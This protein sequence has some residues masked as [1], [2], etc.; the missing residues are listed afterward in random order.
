MKRMLINA[1]QQEELRV[2]LVDGQRLYDLDIESPGHE[3]KKA[4]I[5]KGK[6]TRIEPSLEAAFV[7]YGAE[8]HGFL[9]L[10]EIA[11]EY[12]PANYNSH[13]RPNIKDVLRE[14]QEVIVQID[15]EERGN[16]GAALTTFISL[17]GSYLVL[18]PNNPRAGGISRRIEGDDRTELKEALASLEL[19]DGMGLIVRT[20]GV[21]KSA[22]AL[23]WDLSFRLKHWEAIKKAAESRPAPFLIHQ[24]SN[25]IVRAFRD[26]LRQD[27][28]EILIDNP[29]VLELARQHIAA[30]GRPDFTS[31]I[32]LYTGEIPLFSH[33]QIESQIE[34]AFQREVRLPSGG[35]IVIDTTEALT[36]IDINSARATRGGDIEE[37]AFNTNLEAADEIARQLRL[38]DLGGLIV[39]DFIDMTPVRHQRAVENRL[40]EAVRQDRA[41]IQISHISRFGLL[42]MSRQRLSPSLGESSHHVCPR[43]SGTGTVRDNES[44][45]LSILRLIEEEA[46]KEN[47]KEVHAI[48]PVPIASYLLNEKRAAVSAIEA[49]Q[50]G[51]RCIIVPNDEMQTPHYHVLRVRKGEETSTLSYLLPKLHEEEMALPSDEEPAERKLPEQPALA[52]FIMP[53]A[54]PEATLEKPAAKPAVQK[55]APA[56]PKAQPEQPGLLSRIF[57]ALKKMFA[58]EEFQPEQPKEAPKEA[59]PERQQDRR[60]R[61]NNRRDRNDRNDRSDRN[62]RRDNR[63]ENNE[64]REQREDNRRNRREKQQQNVEDREIRQ[65][66]GDES[67]KSKQRDEQQPRRERN[68]RRNDEKRQAQQEV[69]NLN[70]EAPV[71]Q[72]DTE[73]EERTQVMPRRK[74]RQLTQK[75]RVGAVQTEENDVIAVETAEST[76]GTQVAKV[77]LPAVVENQVEQDESS[78]NRDNAGM[79]RR[80][81]RSPRHLRV[82]GQRRRR[83]RDERYPT[84]S[85]MPLTVACASPEMASGKVWIR[86][87][88]A[89]PEQAVE[90]QAVT[91]EVIAPVAAVEDVVTEAATVVEPQVVDT[92]APQAVE[93][94][95]THPEVIAAPVDAAPQIIAEEDTVVA[96]EVAEEAE[97]VSAAEEPA[98]VTVETV[99]EE[100][101]QD[102]EIQVEPVVE[103]VKEAEVKSDPVEVVAAPAPAHVATAPMTRAPAP[104]YVPEAPRHSDWVRPAFNFEGKGAA[105]GHSA[106]HMATAPATR[107][108]PVE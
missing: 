86:Y 51:V 68:R 63:S 80:S 87:P 70:R 28:G 66:A 34:S 57:G 107:P 36:A 92:A 15:K 105:G 78:E 71:E 48:V 6:I 56:A 16:K 67:E 61:Q 7:D 5:Y 77:D 84:Q 100:V 38:R 27:I 13:G 4:N 64:G 17:A 22:E 37:T 14:G 101:V 53:E 30:L 11:R 26:Y 60:K 72:Q 55:A 52:T 65:Q 32:K 21:G 90:E 91:E 2:A 69:K 42:E 94:E 103:E 29:K 74:Q 47:T 106:T 39:I 79:P 76:T 49:R 35:S 33:Y 19:P 23:Q 99:T 104:E 8:R 24:E 9:P 31:K 12:F 95:T 45:S 46:L 96:E 43:C 81:R 82:S 25:V 85:P 18:M 41:R 93:V 83:Y 44:L 97:P 1:T 40:R 20:A 3:Q 98:D 89:R 10:K 50:G 88:V 108:Q 73:Q 75:V 58:G 62:E 54:P 59:K 102:V